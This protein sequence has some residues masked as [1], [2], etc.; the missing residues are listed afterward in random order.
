MIRTSLTRRAFLIRNGAAVAAAAL[1]PG[2][3]E[4]TPALAAN[5]SAYTWKPLKIG[6]GGFVTGLVAHPTTPDLVYGREDVGGLVR[7]DEITQTWT[8]LLRSD[9]VPAPVPGDYQVESVAVAATNDHLVFAAVGAGTPEGRVLRS[10]DRGKTWTDNGQRWFIEGNNDYRTGPERLAVD[11]GN[12]K[13]VYF[14]TRTQGLWRTL[15]GGTTWAQVPLSQLP[16]GN[17]DGKIG[18]VSV[19][20]D[21]SGGCRQ[22]RTLRIWVIVAGAGIY[23]SDNA[24]QSWTRVHAETGRTP[25]DAKISGDG[26]LYVG[27]SAAGNLPS[28]LRR[29]TAS[30]TAGIDVSP[31]PQ[32]GAYLFGVDPHDSDRLLVTDDAVR[33]G[34]LYRS[35]DGGTTWQSMTFDLAYPDVTW[36]SGTSERGWLSTGTLVFDPTHRGRVWFPQGVGVWRSDDAFGSTTAMTWNFV[37]KGIEEMVTYDLIAPPGGKPVSAV[38]DRNGFRHDNV[39]AYPDKPII[40]TAFSAG[41]SLAYAGGVP[42]YVVAVSSDTRAQYAPLDATWTSDPQSAYSIDG[43]RTWKLFSGT[44]AD[45]TQRYGGNIAVSADASSIVWMPTIPA[46]AQQNP[47]NVPYVSRDNG[48]SWTAAT[49]ITPGLGVHNLI[50]WG[51]K[52]ALAADLV[53]PGLFYLYTTRDG[54]EFFRSAD[55]GATWTR[56]AGT[57]PGSDGNDAHVFGQVHAVPGKA[58]HVWASTAQGGLWSSADGGDTWV[59]AQGVQQA[60]SFGFGKAVSGDHPAVYAWARIGGTWGVWRSADQAQTWTLLAQYPGGYYTG[61]NVVTGDMNVAG[62]VYV[63]F[64]GNGFLYGQPAA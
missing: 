58:G 28:V 29:F 61:V 37:S 24:G 5:G 45:I 20:F 17:T 33:D 35:I 30:D 56:A 57:A 51:S 53:T 62:R 3:L 27:Y 54:G 52:R 31:V 6:G 41:T 23:R 48:Q 14:G 1:L 64:T 8:Q 38:A 9:G 11:P 18:V 10:A 49:G 50:W 63:G 7:W 15:D 34:H 25:S 19:L 46:N 2:A 13:V 26:V 16:G 44:K 36:P 4:A 32:G 60:T 42:S 40:G 43:G 22:H 12:A 55:G 47:A 59:R 39:N 21:P